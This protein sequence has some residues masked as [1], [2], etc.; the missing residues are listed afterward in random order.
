MDN[1]RRHED[2]LNIMNIHVEKDTYYAGLNDAGDVVVHG[3]IP[4]GKA[5]DC[6]QPDIR[7]FESES[8]YHTFCTDRNITPPQ[9]EDPDEI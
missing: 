8:E 6:G 5:F 4:A 1:V 2:Q 7:F 3:L 9:P